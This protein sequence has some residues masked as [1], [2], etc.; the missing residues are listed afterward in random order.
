[1]CGRFSQSATPEAIAE[2]FGLAEVPVLAPRYNIAPSQPIP[3]IR[4]D[5][6]DCERHLSMVRWGLVPSWT[7]DPKTT[8]HPINARVE[9][10]PEKPTFRDAFRR[11][12]CLIPADG[13]YEWATRDSKKQPVRY[14][15]K[16]E[17]LFAFAGLWERWHAP[18]G[19]VLETATIL[20]TDANALV[21]PVHDRMP[22]ILAPAAYTAWLDPDRHDPASLMPL[23]GP[24]PTS[25]MRSY[26]VSPKVNATSSEGPDLIVPQEPGGGQ[27]PLF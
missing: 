10:A 12:R 24:Y 25:E 3:I 4:L 17:H 15:M 27:M 9:T 8:P 2:A 20:T 23:L 26:P 19:A 14:T 6:N 1:V 13:F 22:V 18:D 11:R 5:P 7:K 21:R 16:D